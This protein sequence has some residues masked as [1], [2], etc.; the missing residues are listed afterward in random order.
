VVHRDLKPSN[1]MVVGGF[2]Y[3]GLKITDFGIAKMAEQEIDDA[4]A[5]GDVTTKSSKTVMGALAYLAPEVIEAPKSASRP[6]DV[7][8]VAAIAWE[9]LTGAPPFGTGLKAIKSIGSGRLPTLSNDITGHPQFS[10]LASAVHDV[11]L[12]CLQLEPAKRPTA[13]QVVTKCGELCYQQPARQ[14]G[15]IKNFPRN[16]FGFIRADVEQEQVFF[17]VRSIVGTRPQVGARVWFTKFDGQPCPRAI[18][19]LPLT[20]PGPPR[21]A[22]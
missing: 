20:R 19:V 2:K 1:I 9:L 22:N 8:A 18:P 10:G 15:T 13:E 11:L 7:W 14:L 3:L 12:T 4:V 16:S 17:H 6:A 5:G 21:S